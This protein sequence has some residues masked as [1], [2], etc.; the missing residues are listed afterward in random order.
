MPSINP[1]LNFDG[2]AEEA[3]NFYKD[4][5][6]GDFANV[7]RFGDMPG[8]EKLPNE[9]HNKIMHI[10]L[11]IGKDGVLMASDVVPGMGQPHSAGN[12]VTISVNVDS[13]NEARKIFDALARGGDVTMALD[14]TFW[15]AYFGQLTD[16]FGIQWMVN[17]DYDRK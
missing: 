6:G 4:A 1:Y 15:G 13:E 14:K 10:V 17:Y 5:F 2:N 12:N 7:Q 9:V 16:K 8:K 3:F 11:P